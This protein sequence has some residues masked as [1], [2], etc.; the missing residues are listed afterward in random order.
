MSKSVKHFLLVCYVGILLIYNVSIG[1]K[2]I[3]LMDLKKYT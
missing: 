1:L 3:Y 2:E